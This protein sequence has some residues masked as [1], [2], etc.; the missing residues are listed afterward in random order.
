MLATLIVVTAFLLTA[1]GLRAERHCQALELWACNAVAAA[2]LAA[3]VVG[4][5]T[6]RLG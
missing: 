6:G 3:T 5:A 1:L 2:L 4:H